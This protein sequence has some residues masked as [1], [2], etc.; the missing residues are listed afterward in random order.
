[1]R[2]G[3]GDCE[4]DTQLY[5]LRRQ[6]QTIPLRPKVF[7]L[8]LYLVEQRERVVSREE[9]V[10]EIWAGRVIS[11][12]T[13]DSTIKAVRKAIG[14]IGRPPRYVET[15]RGQGYRFIETVAV[16]PEGSGEGGA[17]GPQVRTEA[18]S[19]VLGGERKLV[20]VLCC[21][22]DIAPHSLVPT[23]PDVQYEQTRELCERIHAEAKRFGGTIQEPVT[24]N[25]LIILFGVPVAHED[26][27]SRAALA[28]LGIKALLQ[29]GS[30]E[31][32]LAGWRIGLYT[33]VVA[34]DEIGPDTRGTATVLGGAVDA[35]VLLQEQ[36]SLNTV[37]CSES[38]AH[39]IEGL[40]RLGDTQSFNSS[41]TSS[42]TES[43]R[44]IHS[45]TGHRAATRR[46][47]SIPSPF[48]GRASVLD[49]LFELLYEAEHGRGQVVGVLGD[50]GMGK[51]RLLDEFQRRTDARGTGILD[52]RCFSFGQATPYGPICELL[53][54]LCGL[55]ER[56][57]TDSLNTKVDNALLAAGLDPQVSARYFLEL[58]ERS[59]GNRAEPA[60]NPQT[61]KSQTFSNL[62]QLLINRS[63]Q[64]PLILQVED[65]HWIDP[66][67]EEYLLALVEQ[68]D[69]SP[70]LLI[71]TYRPGYQPRWVNK[72]YVAQLSLPPLNEQDG[73]ELLR[74]ISE[75]Q[76]DEELAREILAKA[77]G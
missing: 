50:P 9:L 38:T 49:T 68:L 22:F 2:Y 4:L 26:H 29:T 54:Q 51:T 32:K 25:R 18:P 40:V 55:C 67:S 64:S 37:A 43:Y 30:L 73:L 69:G 10:A 42:T 62:T 17:I 53:G 7:Q 47:A 60:L 76:L 11:D 20:T 75:D 57:T 72:S 19:F 77:Q 31:H 46:R 33:G 39:R 15:R 63:Q 70:I 58:L 56:E 3:F 48:V 27:A 44:L 16:N 35:A 28:A 41:K 45:G 65:L 36:A 12:A 61:V 1:M 23:D 66:T 13:M 5:V 24:G 21:R 71:V 34:V 14:D 52:A 8:L 59:A 74:A 6:G